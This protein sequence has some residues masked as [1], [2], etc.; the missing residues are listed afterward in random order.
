MPKYHDPD[1]DKAVRNMRIEL[2]KREREFLLDM[3][4]GIEKPLHLGGKSL[5]ELRAL[6]ANEEIHDEIWFGGG[7]EDD[8]AR[9]EAD[10]YYQGFVN[11][12]GFAIQKLIDAGIEIPEN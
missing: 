3:L 8:N 7:L 9:H 4:D 1:I 10:D 6:Y 12:V 2:D 5:D 11:G